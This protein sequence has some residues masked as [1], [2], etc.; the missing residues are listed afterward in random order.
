MANVKLM[1]GIEGIS[2]KVG[3]LIFKTYKN[4]KVRM[5]R[6]EEHKRKKKLS[7]N[8]KDARTRFSAIAKEVSRMQAEGDTRDRK[9][10]WAEVKG[11][12]P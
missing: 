3:G 2:G 9:T 1:A 10:L 7:Q 6:A 4:G 8:E 11:H 12:T 5:F